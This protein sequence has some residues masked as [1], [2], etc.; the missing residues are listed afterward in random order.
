ML[1]RVKGL[2]QG[3]AHMDDTQ[4]LI[5][6]KGFLT[7]WAGQGWAEGGGPLGFRTPGSSRHQQQP[8]GQQEGSSGKG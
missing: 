6:L 8:G 4:H 5:A 2:R 3:L 7:P 1:N